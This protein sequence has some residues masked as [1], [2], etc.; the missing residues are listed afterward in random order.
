M[1]ALQVFRRMRSLTEVMDRVSMLLVAIVVV[2]VLA[3]LMVVLLM[4][5]AGV[6][7]AAVAEAMVAVG[8]G[9]VPVVASV[10]AVIRAAVMTAWSKV[11]RSLRGIT[12]QAK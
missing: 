3:M 4:V 1:T 6:I 10:M 5:Q 2:I 11:W 7:V 9:K 12:C 8:V